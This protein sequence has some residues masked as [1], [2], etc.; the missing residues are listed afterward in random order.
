MLAGCRATHNQLPGEA[1]GRKGDAARIRSG[2]QGRPEGEASGASIL[3]ENPHPTP[4][5]R[6]S[7]SI[8]FFFSAHDPAKCERFA[9]K[10]MR[11][12]NY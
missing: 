3:R 4:N 10:I 5:A 8:H 7:D 2:T 9:D 6:G 11:Q 12:I 1:L